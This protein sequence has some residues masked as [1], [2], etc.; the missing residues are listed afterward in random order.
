MDEILERGGLKALVEAARERG[1]WFCAAGAV[2]GSCAV[3]EFGR[4]WTVVESFAATGWQPALRAGADVLLRWGRVDQALELAHPKGSQENVVEA[5]QDYAEALVRAGRVDVA[6]GVL[7]PHLRGGRVMGP[8]V[9]M[10]GGQGCGERVLELPAP[11]A[12][13][14]RRDPI[15]DRGPGRAAQSPEVSPWLVFFG[16]W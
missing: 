6:L 11:I 15:E 4:A 10:T 3:G 13:E 14:F 5:W 9:D 7:G 16:R 12:E 2:R 8:L 1:D